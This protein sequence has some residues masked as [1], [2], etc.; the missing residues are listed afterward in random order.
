MKVKNVTFIEY[1]KLCLTKLTVVYTREQVQRLN[2]KACIKTVGLLVSSSG[3]GCK[4]LKRNN[5]LSLLIY[6]QVYRLAY[7]CT[8][9]MSMQR[10][11]LGR[12][13]I[14]PHVLLISTG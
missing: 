12:L 13:V 3:K 2:T 9:M 6:R 4:R 1:R 8:L 5:I 7:I 10:W 11:G 14:S